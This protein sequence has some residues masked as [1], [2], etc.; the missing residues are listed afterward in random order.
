MTRPILP[1]FAYPRSRPSF[2]R[3]PVWLFLL[4]NLA[5]CTSSSPF[6]V[7]DCKVS[8]ARPDRVMA[9]VKIN[10]ISRTPLMDL[11]VLIETAGL[12]RA[13]SLTGYAFSVILK[14]G[15]TR[16]VRRFVDVVPAPNLNEHIGAVISC[17]P[18][19]AKN[20]TGNS[21]YGSS[22]L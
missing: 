3:N 19:S 14:P 11:I 2:F 18:Y 12:K 1:R 20:S 13:G 5:S 21:W 22:P 10:N 16:N 8:K 7:S 15:E 9:E 6:R 17:T 4:F